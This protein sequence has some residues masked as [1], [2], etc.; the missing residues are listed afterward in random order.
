[1]PSYMNSVATEE[2]KI[3]SE[4]ESFSNE[5]EAI[6]RRPNIE[7]SPGDKGYLP[8]A[9]KESPNPVGGIQESEEEISKD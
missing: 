7:T 4:D 6:H 9:E 5:E 2:I 1:M 8:S 3:A